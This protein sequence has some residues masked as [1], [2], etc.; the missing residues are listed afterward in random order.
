[1]NLIECQREMRGN[2]LGG[3]AGQLIS[4]L[5]WLAAAIVSQWYLPGTGMAVLFFSLEACSYS[6]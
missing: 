4:G 5:I 1:M 6:L 2:F 3:F